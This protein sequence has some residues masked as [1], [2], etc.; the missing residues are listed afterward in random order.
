MFKHF[1]GSS[2]VDF[3]KKNAAENILL[4][5]DFFLTFEYKGKDVE[6]V[7]DPNIETSLTKK[8]LNVIRHL[9]DYFEAN[10]FKK[11]EDHTLVGE[12]IAAKSVVLSS[13]S[14]LPSVIMSG[15]LF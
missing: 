7:L 1:G 8:F 15:M 12:E 11:I 9:N 4:Y 13:L 14:P 3:F 2:S 10:V 5:Y 6:N